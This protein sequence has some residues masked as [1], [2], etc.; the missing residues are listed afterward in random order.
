M[1]AARGRSRGDRRAPGVAS[2]CRISGANT[3]P[4][5]A[6]IIAPPRTSPT[7]DPKARRAPSRSCRPKLWPTRIV[8]AMPKPNTAPKVRNMMMFAFEVAASAPSP[9]KRPTQ[10]ALIEPFSDWRMLEPSV[11]S[12]KARSV[13]PICPVVRSRWPGLEPGR[14][15]DPGFGLGSGCRSLTH[16]LRH[17]GR[18]TRSGEPCST[19][20][21]TDAPL[22]RATPSLGVDRGTS[23]G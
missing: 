21:E 11:G 10:I 8:A 12:A 22:L 3:Q 2:R 14:P 20:T 6:M 1:R 19:S 15:A 23:A 13:R 7:A 5:A 4:S 17:V 18:S 9:R 16:S